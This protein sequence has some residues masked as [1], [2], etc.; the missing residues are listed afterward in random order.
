MRRLLTLESVARL[1]GDTP[2]IGKAYH[3]VSGMAVLVSIG[4]GRRGLTG[5]EPAPYY[6]TLVRRVDFESMYYAR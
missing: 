2:S 6:R 5:V 4:A 1:H 3:V